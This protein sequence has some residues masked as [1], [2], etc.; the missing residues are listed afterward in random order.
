MFVA[1]S[2]AAIWKQKKA[3]LHV[4]G[5][6]VLLAIL[7]RNLDPGFGGLRGLVAQPLDGVHHEVE[8]EHPAGRLPVAVR[9]FLF[10][11]GISLIEKGKVYDR[12]SE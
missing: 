8:V 12:L 1:S 3:R 10:R 7:G 6:E 11:P 4:C 9:L 2:P 5:K